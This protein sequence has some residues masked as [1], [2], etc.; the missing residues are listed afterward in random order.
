MIALMSL[1]SVSA[2]GQE[3]PAGCTYEDLCLPEPLDSCA[4][5]AVPSDD[6]QAVEWIDHQGAWH[7]NTHWATSPHL[8]GD[9]PSTYV[10]DVSEYMRGGAGSGTNE[11]SCAIDVSSGAIN[12]WG[13]YNGSSQITG[14]P[15]GGEP[16][17]SL[18]EAQSDTVWAALSNSGSVV[19]WGNVTTNSFDANKPSGSG[20]D[21]IAVGYGPVG[22]VADTGGSGVTCW[23]NNAQSIVSGAPTTGSFTHLAIGRY[24]AVGVKTDG[25]LVMWGGSG[26]AAS[27]ALRTN[28]SGLTGVSK[29]WLQESGTEFMVA[30]NTDQT[31]TVCQETTSAQ[32]RAIKNGPCINGTNCPGTADKVWTFEPTFRTSPLPSRQDAPGDI[33]GVIKSDPNGQYSCGDVICWGHYAETTGDPALKNEC[34]DPDNLCQ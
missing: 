24:N 21:T 20:Y 5:Q 30:Y 15:T 34:V 9:H 10:W 27:V 28:C 13:N 31:V 1:L 23:G 2:W 11:A 32:I 8:S 14:R 18:T 19:T 26:L 7:G 4:W 3:C 22:C 17:S 6:F 29:V 33:C 16:Y 25:T 12:C